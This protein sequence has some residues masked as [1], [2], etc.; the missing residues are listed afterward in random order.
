MNRDMKQF[1]KRLHI[2][3]PTEIMDAIYRNKD[4]DNIDN[5]VINLLSEYYGVDLNGIHNR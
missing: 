1:M 5:I 2:L 4:M 3:V